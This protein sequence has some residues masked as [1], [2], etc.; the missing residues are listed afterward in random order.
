MD[1]EGGL[2]SAALADEPS[3]MLAMERR[4][5]LDHFTDDSHRNV[6]D[7]MSQ[8]FL[9]HGARPT[10]DVVAHAYPSYVFEPV[11]QPVSY[12]INVLA[13]RLVKSTIY[14]GL[15]DAA[16]VF[17][18]EEGPDATSKMQATLLQAL[19][20]GALESQGG[21]LVSFAE[22]M[23]I[24]IKDWRF[25]GQ[26]LGISYGFPT[27]DYHTSGLRA[28][29]FVMLTGLPKSKKSWTLLF[30]ASQVHV[31]GFPVLFITFEMSNMEQM[32]R[33]ATLWGKI[34]Q[35]VMQRRQGISS[36]HAR[37]L[38]RMLNIR[39][40]LPP[41]YGL[42][43]AYSASTVSSLAALIKQRQVAVVFI[44][45]IYLMTDERSGQAG[46]EGPGPLTSISRDLKRMAKTLKVSV[47]ATTQTL[48]SK[49]QKGRTNLFGMGYTNA[50]SQDA[51]VIIG[52]EAHETQSNLTVMRIL[53]NRN[54]M[55]NIEFEVAWDLNIGLVEEIIQPFAT[56]TT[57]ASYGSTNAGS[58]P[59][60]G[61]AGTPTGAGDQRWGGDHG[62]VPRASL[63]T[64][65]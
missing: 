7:Y 49:I 45:G 29:Q 12:Y 40:Q 36:I 23:R 30:M 38:K 59:V 55:Q 19:E 6:W 39:D 31:T 43:D 42:D 50:F 28:E 41:F 15:Q 61:G 54:G 53:G 3:F 32:E 22:S 2:I 64:G 52:V 21:Q 46:H 14:Q 65:P 4:V 37:D 8:H 33:L 1:A 51:D 5:K 63:Q 60:P 44:D 9:T 17:N 56:S 34:P 20:Q 58:A 26:G 57:G 13:D 10:M 11:D 62:A 48:P 18:D 35:G 27:L 47:V 24:R 16:A 25:G